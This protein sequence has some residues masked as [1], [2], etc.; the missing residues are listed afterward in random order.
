MNVSELNW[1]SKF[2]RLA[3]ENSPL[4]DSKIESELSEKFQILFRPNPTIQFVFES[5]IIYMPKG[6]H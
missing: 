3:R 4:D 6:K 1:L 5:N 2:L